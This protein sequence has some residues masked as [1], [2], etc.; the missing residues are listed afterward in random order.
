MYA[1]GFIVSHELMTSVYL[2]LAYIL[3]LHCSFD[4]HALELLERMLTLD[5][6]QVSLYLTKLLTSDLI[7]AQLDQFWFHCTIAWWLSRYNISLY[8]TIG[9]S[10]YWNYFLFFLGILQTCIR[11]CINYIC[12]YTHNNFVF[13]IC[14]KIIE[15]SKIFDTSFLKFC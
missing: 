4:R 14:L 9:K 3:L 12:T 8:N 11:L 7:L 2:S 5:P 1:I 15:V 13:E 10:I 6:S